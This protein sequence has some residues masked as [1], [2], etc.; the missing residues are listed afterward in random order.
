MKKNKLKI[1]SCFKV[2][3]LVV[4]LFTLF[5]HTTY[6]QGFTNISNALDLP[7]AFRNGGGGIGGYGAGISFVD[8][9]QDGLDDLTIPTGKNQPILFLLNN[10]NGFD[11][12]PS[13]VDD[14]TEIKQVLWIDY[15][16]DSDL[17][18]YITSKFTNKL[19]KNTGNLNLVDITAT[20]GFNDPEAISYCGSWFDYD[21][22]GLLDLCI[23]HRINILEGHTKLYKNLGNDQFLDITPAVGLSNIGVSVLSMAVFDMNNDGWEDIFLGQDFSIGCILMKN[24]GDGTF[25]N[26]SYSSNTNIQNDCMTVTVGD[27]NNDGWMDLYLT[28][29]SQGN[30]SLLENQGDETFIEKAALKGVDLA[31]NFC[32]GSIFIDADNDMDLDLHVS[33]I[34]QSYFFDNQNNGQTFIDATTIWGL[35]DDDNYSVG[36]A[37][38]DHNNDGKTDFVEN[39]YF[40]ISLVNPYPYQDSLTSFWQ[41]NFTENNYIN[42]NL[43]GTESNKKAVGTVTHVYVEEVHQM[44]R[45]GCGEG[46]SSQNSYTQFFGLGTFTLIDSIIVEWPSGLKTTLSNIEGNQLLS[47]TEPSFVLGCIDSSSCNYNPSANI[48]DGSCWYPDAYLDCFGNCLNDVDADGICDE[49]EIAG[50]TDSTSCNYNPNATDDD[51][52]C[53][54]A[55]LYYDCNGTCINDTDADNVC[56]ELEIAGC[57]DTTACNYNNLATDDATCFY[58]ENHSIDGTQEALNLTP[59]IYNYPSNPS[60]DYYW[61]ISGADGNIISGQ[62]TT[63]IEVIWDGIGESIVKVTETNE[64]L[65]ENSNELNVTIS[66]LVNQNTATNPNVLLYPNPVENLLQIDLSRRTDET[67]NLL[68]YDINGRIHLQKTYSS[69]PIFLDINPFDN[70]IY[71]LQLINGT[72]QYRAQVII[73]H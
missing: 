26:I 68:L 45:V 72:E 18:L 55:L 66:E 57:M 24:K 46:F 42:I 2:A 32:W 1:W 63:S 31:G 15:D 4:C 20:C 7:Q 35:G 51:N 52:S 60:S 69:T 21:R 54:Y 3:S 56:D 38:G 43:E 11:E 19:Y 13:L 59:Y 47:I 64:G 9:N 41:N 48:D 5:V 16:N 73:I 49:L 53:T 61:E 33:T 25:E 50:C 23:S 70:G 17:D 37:I 8:F 65:C 30:S 22:D 40:P 67:I 10:G 34:S 28:D 36:A 27:Y 58:F 14:S 62:G 6:A 12:I 44:R 71:Q 29:T 39:N